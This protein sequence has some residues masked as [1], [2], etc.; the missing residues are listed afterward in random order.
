M[1]LQLRPYEKDDVPTILAIEAAVWNPQNTPVLTMQERT[2]E[3]YL[4]RTPF[5]ETF[6][7]VLDGKIVGIVGYHRQFL[8]V[9]QHVREIDIAIAA[10]FQHHGYGLQLLKLLQ[11]QAQKDGV[12]KLMLR[13][14]GSNLAAQHLY[15]KAGFHEEGRLVKQFFINEQYVD[16]IF[17]AYF[18][19]SL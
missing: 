1:T 15:R 18:V 3:E 8:A 4:A 5:D 9:A 14:L 12:K 11:Q 6:V 16:D 13:V 7:G 2:V 19:E 10:D 17:M